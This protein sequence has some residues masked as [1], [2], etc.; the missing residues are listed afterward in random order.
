MG[1]W[2][3]CVEEYTELINRYPGDNIGHANLAVCFSV[4]RNLP[5]AVE[6]ARRA[7]EANPKGAGLRGNLSLFYPIVEISRTARR[8][9][10]SS[11]S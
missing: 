5:K 3:K 9:R 8:K 6:E 1:N 10:V 7:V 4:V 11:N 2:Q